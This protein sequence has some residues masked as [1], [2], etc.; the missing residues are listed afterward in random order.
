MRRFQDPASQESIGTGPISKVALSAVALA[1]LLLLSLTA[2]G[3]EAADRPNIEDQD[4]ITTEGF[5]SGDTGALRQGER[6]AAAAP[7]ADA[8]QET[9]GQTPEEEDS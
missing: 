4:P 2:C 3:S 8:E 6:D 7:T 5:E 9:E 1:L